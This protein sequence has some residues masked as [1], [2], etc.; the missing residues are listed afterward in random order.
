MLK[1][2]QN[3]KCIKNRGGNWSAEA[4]QLEA[5]NVVTARPG[6]A[7]RGGVGVLVVTLVSGV[8]GVA[9]VAVDVAG[10]PTT[11]AAAVH[12][13]GEAWQP[14][15]A[16]VA[17]GARVGAVTA[18]GGSGFSS[19]LLTEAFRSRGWRHVLLE[20]AA[21]D[22]VHEGQSYPG[23]GHAVTMDG[24]PASVGSQDLGRDSPVLGC[25]KVSSRDHFT[26]WMGAQP[27]FYE[28]VEPHK[29]KVKLHGRG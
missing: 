17:V 26:G 5:A 29:V 2:R 20:C 15:L 6:A 3:I 8:A 25:E 12:V 23:V 10:L 18:R 22:R 13:T 16:F 28:L 9:A 27:A 7:A 14:V 24:A 4:A 21:Q 11:R 19:L 1:K